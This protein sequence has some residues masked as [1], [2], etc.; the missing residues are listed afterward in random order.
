MIRASRITIT[1]D[2]TAGEM[3]LTEMTDCTNPECPEPFHTRT[4]RGYA[5]AA[6]VLSRWADEAL[7]RAP[8]KGVG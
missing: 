2:D 1:M 6:E 7:L 3:L 8:T 4:V 5:A